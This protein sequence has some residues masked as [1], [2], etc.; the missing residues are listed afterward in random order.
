MET[1][2]TIG[3]TVDDFLSKFP[4]VVV[5]FFAW[6]FFDSILLIRNGGKLKSGFLI[7]R[8]LLSRDERHYLRY[9]CSDFVPSHQKVTDQ[10]Y[11]LVKDHEALIYYKRR[12]FRTSW[13]YVAYTDLSKQRAFLEF[14]GSLP[15]H[16]IFVPFILS[17]WMIPFVALMF[18]I[19]YAVV[20]SGLED[21]LKEQMTEYQQAK[22]K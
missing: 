6:G 12:F 13:P 16:L 4:L 2:F 17:I 1:L 9:L 10:G 20:S 11:I 22:A 19:N 18:G 8:R 3:Q 15:M 7:W 21:F 5:G 14:R